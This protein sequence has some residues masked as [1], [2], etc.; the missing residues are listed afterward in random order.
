MAVPKKRKSRMKV[1]KRRAANRPAAPGLSVCPSCGE[2]KL[3]HRVCLACGTYN[4]RQVITIEVD[5]D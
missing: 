2:P 5:E 3:P 4:G 1:R